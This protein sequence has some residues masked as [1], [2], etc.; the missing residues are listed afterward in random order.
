MVWEKRWRHWR[1]SGMS[2]TKNV[3]MSRLTHGEEEDIAKGKI[4]KTPLSN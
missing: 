3:V 4:S 1:A 2:T